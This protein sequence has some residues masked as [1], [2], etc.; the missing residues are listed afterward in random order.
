MSAP[1]QGV[2]NAGGGADDTLGVTP[3]STAPSPMY[4]A[5]LK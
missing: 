5:F 1:D 2:T 3:T 4:A